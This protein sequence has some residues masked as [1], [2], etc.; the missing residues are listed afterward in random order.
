MTKDS[1]LKLARDLKLDE[2]KFQA[3][4][5]SPRPKE[6][7]AKDKAEADRLGLSGTPAIFIGGIRVRSYEEKELTRAID[8][9]LT[10]RRG[11]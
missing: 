4:L 2:T 10:G 3:C 11:V 7:L 8:S 9:A 5:A 6:K 1:A